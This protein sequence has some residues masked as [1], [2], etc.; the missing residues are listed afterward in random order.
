[1]TIGAISLLLL[2]FLTACGPIGKFKT[3]G[4]AAPLARTSSL[5]RTEGPSVLKSVVIEVNEWGPQGPTKAGQFEL[6]SGGDGPGDLPL[7]LSLP[8][9]RIQYSFIQS[10]GTRCAVDKTMPATDEIVAA[11]ESIRLYRSTDPIFLAYQNN[12]L[13]GEAQRAQ[14]PMADRITLTYSDGTSVSGYLQC[15]SPALHAAGTER[16]L[17]GL[18]RNILYSLPN[19]CGDI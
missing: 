15:G 9:L 2:P 13:I 11:A 5:A 17:V 16:A 10:T 12:C 6:R 7:V 19:N 1:M 4:D 3:E 8:F 18:A 14:G